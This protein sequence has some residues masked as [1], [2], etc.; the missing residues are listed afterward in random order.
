VTS[1]YE[2]DYKG[3][4]TAMVNLDQR[5]CTD[6]YMS[7]HKDWFFRE[8]RVLAYVQFLESYKSVTLS[9]MAKSFGVSAGFIDKELAHFIS[10]GR[11]NAKIDKVAGVIETC[12]L[13]ET[14]AK[15]QSVIKQGDLL[16]NRVQMLSRAINV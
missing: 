6:R 11:I 16:L 7:L 9:S 15:Y 13:N 10:S 5:I 2:C 1:L 12:R 3:F 4:F 14:N 8:A